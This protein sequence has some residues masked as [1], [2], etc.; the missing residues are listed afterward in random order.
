VCPNLFVYGTLLSRFDSPFTRILAAEAELLGPAYL[1]G[2]LYQ[3]TPR[4][5]GLILSKDPG[6]VALGEVFRMRDPD[7][8][9][10]LLDDYEGCAPRS[11][12][13]FEYARVLT[14]AACDNGRSIEVW[15][16]VYRLPV[17]EEDLIA[18][19]SYAPR[20]SM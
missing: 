18:S 19:G 2:R 12:K 20:L 6:D 4:Y 10:A 14:S 7:V 17:K 8:L 9:L 13:P 5:P 15:S 3:V 1:R 11:P 16:Y